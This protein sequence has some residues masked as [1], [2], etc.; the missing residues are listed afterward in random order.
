MA[1]QSGKKVKNIT[2]N[3]VTANSD[4]NNFLSDSLQ[5]LAGQAG[6][7]LPSAIND[8]LGGKGELLQA[9]QAAASGGAAGVNIVVQMLTNVLKIQPAIA[10]MI[11]PILLQLAPVILE[12]VT[13]MGGSDA[14]EPA[15]ASKS[16]SSSSRKTAEKPT[17]S[18][19][20]KTNATKSA[21]NESTSSPKRK[22]LKRVVQV[23]SE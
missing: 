10:Q 17:T 11:A 14:E 18:K 21:G 16:T 4:Q 8:F 1:N 7:D 19:A 3:E 22:T 12:K 6:G 15:R 2:S 23:D 20:K 5:M 9:S 13:G